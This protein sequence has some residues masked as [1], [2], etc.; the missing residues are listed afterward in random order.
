VIGLVHRRRFAGVCRSPSD[1]ATLASRGLPPNDDHLPP[2]TLGL[3]AAP[4]PLPVLAEA[5]DRPTATVAVQN[6]TTS[7]TLEMLRKQP[8]VGIR[9]FRNCV[10]PLG[11]TDRSDGVSLIPGLS[12]SW[13]R[14]DDRTVEFQ[15]RKGARFH[16]GDL[17][18]AGDAA[19][20]SVPTAWQRPGRSPS[21]RTTA[22]RIGWWSAG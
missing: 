15:L 14:R 21:A 13:Q 6:I 11:D 7:N 2:G 22:D 20:P 10:E 12:T 3:A 17:L 4:L 18:T 9:I 19:S 16:N 1:R 8:G 5:D